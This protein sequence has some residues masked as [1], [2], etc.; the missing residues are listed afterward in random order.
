MGK[1]FLI[2]MSVLLNLI[3][4]GVLGVIVVGQ[5]L[6][7]EMAPL[8]D[9]PFSSD[10]QNQI[11]AQF[12]MWQQRYEIRD[13]RILVPSEARH[14][15]LGRLAYAQL[16]PQD[17][18]LT[19]M[20]ESGNIWMPESQREAQ[21]LI[22]LQMELARS[23]EEFPGVENAKVF[24]I[25]AGKRRLN[26]KTPTTSASVNLKLSPGAEATLKLGTAIAY[27]VS[28]AVNNMKQENVMVIADGQ[29]LTEIQK[30]LQ[31]HGD[32]Q[33]LKTRYEQYYREK[34]IAILEVSNAL[35][36]VDVTPH[37]DETAPEL[38]TAKNPIVEGGISDITMMVC[39]P[40]SYF[41]ELAELKTTD[42]TLPTE[43]EVQAIISLEIPQIRKN[44]LGAIGLEDNQ[45]NRARVV[46]STYWDIS[47]PIRN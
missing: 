1:K 17:T 44:I 15:L 21:R 10:E 20:E 16:L 41:V 33:A 29:I 19:L 40:E 22:V 6:Q 14:K 42:Q 18:W 30:E 23:I 36:Q 39:Y 47:F 38:N 28:S 32:Y 8:L 25:L 34:I 7:P 3:V 2:G 46:V 37:M 13:D 24:I 43:D 4:F 27:F 5:V 11:M 9:Q 35:V 31:V 45:G 12:Q 26:N